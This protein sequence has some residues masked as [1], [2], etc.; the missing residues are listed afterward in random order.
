MILITTYYISSNNDRN[1][2]I[3]KCLIKNS[4][5]QYIKKIYLLNNQTYKLPFIKKANSKKIEQVIISNDDNYILNYKDAINFINTNLQNNICIL[6]NSDIYFDNSLF[7]INSFN[8]SGKF[9]ALLRYDEDENGNKNI[10]KRHNE[11]RDDSQDSWIFKSPLNIDTNKLDFTFRTLGCDSILAKHV[12]DTGIKVCNPSYDIITTHVH[13]TD[14]R[15]YNC[16]NRIHGI[17]CLIKPGHLND[18]IEP[19]F[20]D[21]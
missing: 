8:I 16:D 17:Y 12:Y 1:K 5:N 14:Y 11:P 19:T 7:H 21:Y 13:N 9:Y 20:M 3:E 18:Y 2:E 10:F 6:A 4:D 15:T